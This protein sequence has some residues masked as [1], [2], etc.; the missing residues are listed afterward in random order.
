M[1]PIPHT[2]Q[3]NRRNLKKNVGKLKKEKNPQNNPY[4]NQE[5]MNAFFSYVQNKMADERKGADHKRSSCKK[6]I[7]KFSN[8]SIK[9][10]V[11]ID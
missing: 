8:M 6:E 5:E 7:N 2:T 9:Q 11:S 4:K 1:D 3:K 10:K